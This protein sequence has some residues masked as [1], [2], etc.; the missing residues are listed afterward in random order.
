MINYSWS[1]RALKKYILLQLPGLVLLILLLIVFERWIDIPGWTFWG[2]IGLWVAKDVIL[3]PFV[4]RAYDSDPPEG[5]WMFG[6]HGIAME[7]LDPSGYIFVRGELWKAV[8]TEDGS[9]VEKGEKVRVLG[10]NGLTLI[11]MRDKS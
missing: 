8:L 6:E 3:F 11:V 7:R 4:W 10:K 2:I 1:G 9:P 5:E